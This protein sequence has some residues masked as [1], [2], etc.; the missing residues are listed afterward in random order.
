MA[1][2]SSFRAWD[3]VRSAIAAGD[4]LAVEPARRFMSIAR[5]SYWTGN[6]GRSIVDRIRSEGG[7]KV[8]GP[9]PTGRDDHIRVYQPNGPLDRIISAVLSPSRERDAALREAGRGNA[10]VIDQIRSL[11][12][13]ET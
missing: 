5:W 6:T 11:V 3:E 9:N 2:L 12:C 13:R 7:L 8:L 10:D 4:G 1:N